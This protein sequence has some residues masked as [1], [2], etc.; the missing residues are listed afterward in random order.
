[1]PARGLLNPRMR[2]LVCVSM[3]SA[4]TRLF[5]FRSF[6]ALDRLIYSCGGTPH[7]LQR[8][9]RTRSGLTEV[10]PLIALS[11]MSYASLVSV[12]PLLFK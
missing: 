12:H 7:S 5:E 4:F 8:G 9:Y 10:R 11:P 2:G 1:M 6:T 3:A